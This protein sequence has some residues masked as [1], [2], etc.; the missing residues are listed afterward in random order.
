MGAEGQFCAFFLARL[1]YE[2][3]RL[4]SVQFPGHSIGPKKWLNLVSGLIDTAAAYL[5]VAKESSTPRVQAAKLIREAERLGGLAYKALGQVAGSDATQIPHEVVAPLQ[6]WVDALKIKKTIF[7]RAEHL[8]NY[9]LAWFDLRKWRS[10]LNNP[11]ATLINAIDRIEWPLL[12][13]TVPG[14][15]LGMLPH[16]AVVGHELGHA[17]QDRIKL[18][19]SAFSPILQAAV[20]RIAARIGVTTLGPQVQLCLAEIIG[21]WINELKADA[22]GHQLVGPAFYFALCG[23]L[24]LAGRTYG[25]SPTHPPSDLR[26]KLLVRRLSAGSPSFI[27]VFQT[28]A[29][30][31]ITETVNS[32]HVPLCPP[33]DQLFVELGRLYAPLVAAI[34]VELVPYLEAIADTVFDKTAAYVRKLSAHLVYQPS[35]LAF[36]LDNHLDLICALVPPIEY[37]DSTGLHAASLA[38]ILNVG[39]AALLTR[40]DEMEKPRDFI[41]DPATGKME[42]LH[43]L[44]L[45][46]VELS[47][48]RR[49][50]EENA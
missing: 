2:T 46:G 10:D 35:Q 25:I 20:D 7:F 50:W 24:E 33:A 44:L 5:T 8:P 13:V 34:C 12:R 3:T 27:E 29:G 21:K 36:D 15:A 9:E 39:W 22:V 1:A 6:R 23:Y 26:R 18:D 45:R 31:A 48:A 28:K 42:Q 47:E 40:I 19:L 4:K 14:Q 37:R 38:S 41:F 49:V 16:Y 32:A 43:E 17:I 30:L 11:S